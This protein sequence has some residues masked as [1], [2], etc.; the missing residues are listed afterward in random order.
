MPG[1]GDGIRIAFL[2][3]PLLQFEHQESI[4]RVFSPVGQK[5]DLLRF[6]HWQR[7]GL[8]VLEIIVVIVTDKRG[9]AD[10]VAR[11]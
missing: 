8:E 11:H 6:L 2:S 4:V 5:S 1:N 3:S 9:D 10:S 7:G